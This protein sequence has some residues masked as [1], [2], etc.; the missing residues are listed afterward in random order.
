MRAFIATVDLVIRAQTWAQACDALTS[1]LSE[2]G[3]YTSPDPALHDWSYIPS[4]RDD[5]TDWPKEIELP[6]NWLERPEEDRRV[7]RLF[8]G[9]EHIEP[10][11]VIS[12]RHLYPAARKALAAG[13]GVI[14][15]YPY[16]WIV[17]A[18]ICAGEALRPLQAFARMHD[19]LWIK[20]DRDGPVFDSLPTFEW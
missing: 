8:A 14:I 20:F 16:G 12:N 10:M 4:Q 15:P 9:R 11:L 2:T 1:L 7:D 17:H 5:D 3:M 6:E 19:C 18:N 13:G